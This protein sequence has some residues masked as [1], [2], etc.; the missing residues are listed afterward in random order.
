MGILRIGP[1]AAVRMGFTF[2]GA[3]LLATAVATLRF[4][5][6]ASR[7]LRETYGLLPW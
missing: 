1:L 5:L 7:E 6:F 2:R 4:L 3:G